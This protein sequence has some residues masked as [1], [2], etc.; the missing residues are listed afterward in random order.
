MNWVNLTQ[1][2]RNN[3]PTCEFARSLFVTTQYQQLKDKLKE[4]NETLN[5]YVKQKYLQEISVNMVINDFPY[6]LEQG[7]G[8]Y[9]LFAQHSLAP[10]VITEIITE[11]FPGL[12]TLW[13]VNNPNQQSVKEVWHCHIMVK[14]ETFGIFHSFHNTH[15][16]S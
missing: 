15:L 13:F 16:R 7:I 14:S 2:I 6:D 9:V 12:T 4:Q 8:H 10:E 3:N 5:T 1:C 11:T